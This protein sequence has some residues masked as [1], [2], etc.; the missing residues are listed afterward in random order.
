MKILLTLFFLLFSSSVVADDISDFEIEG[1]SIGDSAL[2][3]FSEEEIKSNIVYEY[4]YSSDKF[5]T[6][7]VYK[8][9]FLKKYDSI[10]VSFKKNDNNYKIHAI[11]GLNFYSDNIDEC[12]IQVDKVSK[13][14]SLMFKNVEKVV[15]E[16]NH[17]ADPSGQSK[18][19]GVYFWFGSGALASVECYDWSKK[20]TK[21]KGWT[22]NLNIY[23]ATKEF[24]DW[25]LNEAYQ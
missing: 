11:S 5:V 4:T 15:D 7:E 22:D 18:T 8:H 13:E 16:K 6:F 20:L 19:K 10:S 12:N 23:L 17:V 3:Y 24:A 21:E 9:S 14:I 2:D 1:I 25:L